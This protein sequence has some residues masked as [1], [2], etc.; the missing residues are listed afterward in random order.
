MARGLDMYTTHCTLKIIHKLKEHRKLKGL[1][2]FTKLKQ[3]L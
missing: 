2:K 3:N 1:F